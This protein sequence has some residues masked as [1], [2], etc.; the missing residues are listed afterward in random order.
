MGSRDTLEGF[1]GEYGDVL[2]RNSVLEP[3]VRQI[4]SCLFI[5]S[6]RCEITTQDSN[7]NRLV[8]GRKAMFLSRTA[9]YS[10]RK[11]SL[12]LFNSLPKPMFVP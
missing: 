6:A 11:I 2:R 3:A 12:K 8:S 7:P 1:L 5:S 9:R 10:R 4:G